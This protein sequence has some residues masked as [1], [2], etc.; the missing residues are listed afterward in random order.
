MARNGDDQLILPRILIAGMAVYILGFN[1]PAKADMLDPEWAAISEVWADRGV[2]AANGDQQALAELQLM[3]EFCETEPGCSTVDPD[4]APTDLQKRAAAAYVELG[5]LYE[6]GILQGDAF[7]TPERYYSYAD[8]VGSP[9]GSHHLGMLYLNSNSNAY[10]SAAPIFL[11]RGARRGLAESALSLLY[12]AQNQRSEDDIVHYARM[13]LALT[14]NADQGER[15]LQTLRSRGINPGGLDALTFDDEP[16]YDYSLQRPEGE[17]TP[18][19]FSSAYPEDAVAACA[20]KSIEFDEEWAML[21]SEDARLKS[22]NT[23]YNQRRDRAER[24][25]PFVPSGLAGNVVRDE[26]AKRS[27]ALK[28]EWDALNSAVTE[29][30]E[31]GRDLSDRQNEFNSRC[32]FAVTLPVY[33]SVCRGNLGASPYCRS[34]QF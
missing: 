32:S 6:A 10:R 24:T 26:I 17:P 19:A 4:M 11:E 21:R 34:I 2:R 13:G 29:L 1:M 7:N 31:W 3:D 33:N 16:D 9:Y 20:M 28:T 5:R 18:Y 30:N 12:I 23:A 15:F 25:Q 8:A 22:E 14:P 27:R